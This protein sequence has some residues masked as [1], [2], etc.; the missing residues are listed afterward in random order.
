[1]NGRVL[2][3]DDIAFLSDLGKEISDGYHTFDE[4]YY[5]RTALFAC[6]VSLQPR[7]MAFKSWRHA[8]GSMYEGYFIAGIFTSGGWST[9]HCESRWW[10][11]F[12]CSERDR[13]PEWDGHTPSDA[14]HR[15]M[16][17][18]LPEQ[19]VCGEAVDREVQDDDL[20]PRTSPI[21]DAAMAMLQLLELGARSGEGISRVWCRE[22]VD[23]YAPVL[24]GVV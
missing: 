3:P 16:D 5:H 14:I 6:L 21:E 22:M 4:L 1:M 10:P 7:Q 24:G 2:K 11:L 9:Y 12:S 18:F 15:L 20:S 19:E 23:K 17:D 8:D 13:A